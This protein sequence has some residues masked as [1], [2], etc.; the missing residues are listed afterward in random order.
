M[1]VPPGTLLANVIWSEFTAY[2]DPAIADIHAIS[3]ALESTYAGQEENLGGHLE[4]SIKHIQRIREVLTLGGASSSPA[5]TALINALKPYQRLVMEYQLRVDIN[6][7]GKIYGWDYIYVDNFTTEGDEEPQPMIRSLASIPEIR[8]KL[9]RGTIETVPGNMPP[10]GM[11]VPGTYRSVHGQI[12]LTEYGTT[13]P[14]AGVSLAFG[15]LGS[16]PTEYDGYYYFAGMP[17]GA[18]DVTPT[19]VGYTFSPASRTVV[20]A[21][22]T[23]LGVDFAAT[24]VPPAV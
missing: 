13:R 10:D 7:D 24:T 12:T 8:D 16:A 21:D 15:S 23:V 20:V 5:D 18:Y 3:L 14:L 2:F 22:G 6:G 1:P 4:G 17:A 9:N 19:L 11:Y